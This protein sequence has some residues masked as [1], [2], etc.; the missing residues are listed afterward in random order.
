[1]KI[2]MSI[3]ANESGISI[4]QNLVNNA[5]TILQNELWVRGSISSS[6][7]GD[8]ILASYQH[9]VQD[10]DLTTAKNFNFSGSGMGRVFAWN[11]SYSKWDNMQGVCLKNGGNILWNC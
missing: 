10:I 8:M 4:S 3:N 6:S 5:Y 1:M 9:A 2:N 11:T 7:V